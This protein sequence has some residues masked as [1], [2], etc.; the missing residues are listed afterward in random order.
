MRRGHPHFAAAP[1]K[2]AIFELSSVV[3]PQEPN[4][5][6]EQVRAFFSALDYHSNPQV[7]SQILAQLNLQGDLPQSS[8][9]IVKDGRRQWNEAG[10][11]GALV[12]PGLLALNVLQPYGTVSDELPR[13]EALLSTF[14]EVMK[15]PAVLALGQRYINQVVLKTDR[16]PDPAELFTI[17]PGFPESRAATRHR[18]FSVQ[19]EFGRYDAGA[20]TVTLALAALLQ[21]EAVYSLDIYARTVGVVPNSPSGILEWHQH[22]H[23]WVVDAFLDTITQDARKEF[24]EVAQ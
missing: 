24:R 4:V 1:L 17:Y 11:R 21:S 23:E 14:F 10:T 15:P 7:L 5:W 9:H 16:R 2:E 13:L 12:A 6:S 8:V 19:V 3:T 18:P 20:V 22:A